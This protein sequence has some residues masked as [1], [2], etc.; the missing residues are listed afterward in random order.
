M[1]Q[2][3][4]RRG[5]HLGPFRDSWVSSLAIRAVRNSSR[6]DS[7]LTAPV[8]SQQQ[9]SHGPGMERGALLLVSPRAP[10]PGAALKLGSHRRPAQHQALR[11]GPGALTASSYCRL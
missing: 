2:T 11:P 5:K 7:R 6:W 1:C 8:Q 4:P 3:W 10:E 9:G